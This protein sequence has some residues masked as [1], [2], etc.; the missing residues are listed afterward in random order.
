MSSIQYILIHATKILTP[1]SESAA[2]DAEVL[3]STALNKDR[4]YLRAWPEQAL[5][6]E[7]LEIFESYLQQRLQGTPLAYITG[8]RE[9]WSREFA[10]NQ[11]VLIP[12][13]DTELIVDISLKRIPRNTA[14]KIVDLGTGSGVIAITL[15]A[16]RPKLEVL[17][18]DKSA[19]ALA[20]AKQN[21]K[22][23]H[24][25]RI[26][27]Y[28]SN[29]FEG[30][31]DILFDFIISN[32]PYI[33]EGDPHLQRG[34]LRFEPHSALISSKQ[35][36]HDI[37]RII[38]AARHHLNAEGC[39]MIEHGYNQKDHIKTLFEQHGYQQ[40]ETFLDLAGNPRVTCGQWSNST[41]NQ[42][43]SHDMHANSSQ[44]ITIPRRLMQQLLH[45]AQ[46]TPS[47]EVCGLISA[48]NDIPSICYPIQNV[49]KQPEIRFQLDAKQQIATF[50]H[51]REQ[52]ETLFGIYHSHPTRPAF[53][54]ANDLQQM[55]AYP[56]AL[57]FIIS[58]DTKGVLELRCFKIIHKLIQEITL[59]ITD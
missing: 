20:I 51:M 4:A 2:L 19:E 42:N 29:W 31:P 23:H 44:E 58:L 3:L 45:I 25:S 24:V 30:L 32:P 13:H 10:V 33:A 6:P 26:Q 18:C 7:Y 52:G 21:A 17:A 46:E 12:R 8:I 48:I 40:V 5:T 9:F 59:H 43:E 37:E 57:R 56:E 27:F 15:A 41:P 1:A 50:R 55:S 34:D 22:K 35:G 47:I 49:S 11:H 36:L 39:L 14:L 54:S 28:Q 16:E 53:P 38:D